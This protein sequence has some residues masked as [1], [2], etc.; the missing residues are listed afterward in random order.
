MNIRKDQ[1]KAASSSSR[2]HSFR[3]PSEKEQEGTSE[4]ISDKMVTIGLDQWSENYSSQ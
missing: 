2:S 1:V 4:Q 3:L